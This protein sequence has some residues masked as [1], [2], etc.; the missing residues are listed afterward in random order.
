MNLYLLTQEVNNGYDTY[1]SCVVAAESIEDAVKIPPG[2]SLYS[3]PEEYVIECWAKPEHV[4]VRLIGIAAED[5][6]AGDVICAS[7]KAG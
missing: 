1:D 4:T 7:F 3:T 2:S 5:V 6:Q